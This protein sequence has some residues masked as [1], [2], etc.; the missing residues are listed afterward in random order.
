MPTVSTFPLNIAGPGGN[1]ILVPAFAVLYLFTLELDSNNDLVLSG[2]DLKAGIPTL[3]IV[4]NVLNTEQGSMLG[5]PEFGVRYK[6]VR[7][8]TPSVHE[9]WRAEVRR[10]LRYLVD[11]RHITDLVVNV[12]PVRNGRLLFEVIFKDTVSSHVAGVAGVLQV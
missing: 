6:I 2:S 5:D 1:G 12:D 3:E 11:G 8:A 10:S 9:D 7:K 4:R